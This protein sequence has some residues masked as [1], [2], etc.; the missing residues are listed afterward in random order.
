VKYAINTVL[1][2]PVSEVCW[3][4]TLLRGGA[5]K[6]LARPRRKQAAVT[7][8]GIYSTYEV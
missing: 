2:A 7:K 4:N 1:M 5:G 3:Q 6:S 8:L